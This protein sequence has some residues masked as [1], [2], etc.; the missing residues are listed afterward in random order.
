MTQSIFFYLGVC[1]YSSLWEH[2]YLHVLEGSDC[3]QEFVKEVLTLVTLDNL[4]TS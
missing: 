4:H 2:V 3:G 1:I